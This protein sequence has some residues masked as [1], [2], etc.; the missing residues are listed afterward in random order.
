MYGSKWALKIVTVAFAGVCVIHPGLA[1]DIPVAAAPAPAPAF[2]WTGF[3]LGADISQNFA[4]ALYKRPFDT[5]LSDTSIGSINLN[6]GVGGYVG[7][8]FQAS[9]WLVVGL[10]A[11]DTWLGSMVR[12]QG[13]TYDFLEHV[14]SVIA[15][16]GRAGVLVRPDTMIY[17]KSG[18]RG[19]M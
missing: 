13:P 3:Y 1:A 10:E 17:G 15:V 18:R 6:T 7:F 19:C 12:E 16:T 9:P 4:T 11:S 8:N 14:N 5:S 2:N